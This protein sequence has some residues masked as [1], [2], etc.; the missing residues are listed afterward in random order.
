MGRLDDVRRA[1]SLGTRPATFPPGMDPAQ[2]VGRPARLEGVRGDRSS[3]WIAVGRIER[4]P[5]QPRE[6]FDPEALGRLAESLRT[7]GQ[8]QP[9]RV[10]WDEERGAYIVLAGE[11]RWRAAGMAGLA[12]LQ[13][14]IHDGALADDERLALQLVEN[15]LRDD[16]RPVEQARAYKRLMDARGWTM[17]ELAAE[18]QVHQTSVGRALA[19]LELPC[20]VQESVERG[21]L[22][23][24]AAAEIAKLV[25]PAAQAELAAAVVD[26]RLT[27]SEVAEAVQAIRARRPA[28][29]PR[30]EPVSV[31]VGG[32][33]VTVRWK[34][35]G[36][37]LDAAQA[38]RKALK[39][40]QE[41]GRVST[42]GRASEDQGEAA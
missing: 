18:L 4:D 14:V 27:R 6:E 5:E 8:L 12:E 3:A 7:R 15:A 9:I 16:L 29:S 34:R 28:P 32:A 42:A 33:V 24:S 2:A 19:L 1:A 38:L 39:A 22:A 20:T 13:C 23:P 25:D 40:V 37:A 36:D 26:Q 11:R 35:G 17:T 30:P 21:T 10:R 41:K 31:D